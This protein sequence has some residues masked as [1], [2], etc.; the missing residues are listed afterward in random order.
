MTAQA[1]SMA[2]LRT[3]PLGPI[4]L[5]GAPG[6]GKGTQAKIIMERYGIQQIST[7]DILRDNVARATE[8]GRKAKEFMDR[9]ELVPDQLV[10]DM[11][12]DR[13]RQT[14]CDRGFI[15]DGFPRTVAQ[16]EWL[17]KLLENRLFNNKHKIPPVVVNVAVSYNQLLRRL[18]GRR[19]CPSCGRIYNVYFQPPRVNELCDADGTK[20]VTRKDDTEEVISERLKAYERQTLPLVDYYR[21]QGRLREINGEQEMDKVTAE[22]VRAIEYGDRV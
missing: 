8:L 6:A 14:D 18:T 19:S 5:L 13:L 16:A 21:Q 20:L 10:C 3:K 15:L 1:I 17:D 9:G 11:V 4:I 7:G 22:A 2:D 12:A